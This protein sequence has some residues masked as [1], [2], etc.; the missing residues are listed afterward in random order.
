VRANGLPLLPR[1]GPF[2]IV[3]IAF[4]LVGALLEQPGTL[5]RAASDVGGPLPGLSPGELVR[6]EAGA[7]LFS[8][9][10]GPEDGLGPV[11]NGRSCVEC[12]AL[13]APG[14]ADKT[15]S[16]LIVRIGRE[17]GDSYDDLVDLGGPV[18][19]RHSVASLLPGCN[20]EG[21]KKPRAATAVSERQPPSLFGLGLVAAIPD[22]TLQALAAAQ[23]AGGEVA[24]RINRVDGAVGRFGS[25]AQF[26]TLD[27]F[28]ADAL[29]NELG[30][31]NPLLPDEKASVRAAG[32]ACDL[33]P[34]A[35]DDGSAVAML[36]DFVAMTAPPPR[37][38]I[39]PA[40][41]RG[42]AIFHEVGCASCHTP[43]LRTGPSP[44]AALA[45]QDVP[46]YSDLL[47]HDM[48]E[49]LA[50]GVRQGEAGGTEWRTA[51]L[52]GLGRRLWFL[53]DGR[54]TDLRT[55]IELHNG[56]AKDSR[57]RLFERKRDDL[58]DVLTF[59]RS[60]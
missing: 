45:H 2:L 53:H 11:F 21:E 15:R 6:F 18:L 31:T 38:P 34:D 9:V 3:L 35:E 29:R 4:P 36:T 46:L 57:D 41:R 33:R 40:E 27:A 17:F 14:G 28:I 56:E 50:D 7:S 20:V 23:Q 12:H 51:P 19:S 22:E 5:A 44:I 48:G 60:L 43:T 39:G 55:A 10:H 24:G 58:Q 37:G 52:W 47:I 26:P 30:I 59:L 8:K 13:P 1:I 42:A 32:P 16:H 25:K 49:Y 54:A